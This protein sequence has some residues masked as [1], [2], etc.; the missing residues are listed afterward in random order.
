MTRKK[1][2]CIL[3]TLI[4]VTFGLT[5]LTLN[6]PLPKEPE[7][8]IKF[9]EKN[10]EI[11]I[12]EE[13]RVGYTIYNPNPKENLIWSTTNRAVASV[14][15]KGV[16]KGVAF[17][18]VI[19]T[20]ELPNREKDTLNLRVKSYPVYFRLK[21]NI[22]PNNGWFNEKLEVVFD[23]LNVENI[24]YCFEH[25]EGCIPHIEY[26]NK[27]VLTDGIW[28]LKAKG[29][30]RNGKEVTYQETFKVDLV[31]PS[32]TISRIGKMNEENTSIEVLCS[33]DASGIYKYEWYIDDKR[34]YVTDA[35]LIMAKEIYQLGNHK[36]SV[37]VFDK[38][39]NFK[40][41]EVN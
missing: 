25:Y 18:D 24:V 36:Y 3:L 12:G 41:Y 23:T 1:D 27:I 29:L 5:W 10:V 39:L 21:T 33:P 6:R 35:S 40:T 20:V 22:E 37:K 4:V 32:C 8:T 30:D 28:Y 16:I 14:N 15:S 19:I 38:A 9:H 26:S 13:T 34:V 7:H 11:Y 31:K 17:G 2:K